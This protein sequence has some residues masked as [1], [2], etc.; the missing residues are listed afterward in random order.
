VGKQLPTIII[1]RKDMNIQDIRWVT[2][3]QKKLLI[4]AGVTKI[5]DGRVLQSLRTLLTTGYCKCAEDDRTDTMNWTDKV[6]ALVDALGIDRYKGDISIRIYNRRKIVG[7]K[8]LRHKERLSEHQAKNEEVNAALQVQLAAQA[9]ASDLEIDIHFIN[10]LMDYEQRES[11]LD[12]CMRD[13]REAKTKAMKDLLKA[14]GKHELQ[15]EFQLVF[16]ALIDR[17]KETWLWKLHIPDD[18]K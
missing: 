4:A 6:D 8:K 12:F 11:T 14:N 18:N 17:A 1:K 9:E 15:S 3:K 16:D 10:A 7:N 2:P 13:R 5:L